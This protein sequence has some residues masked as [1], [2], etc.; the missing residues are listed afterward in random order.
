M[1][2]N[3]LETYKVVENGQALV[4]IPADRNIPDAVGLIQSSLPTCCEY[5]VRYA[6]ARLRGKNIRDAH[7]EALRGANVIARK[8]DLDQAGALEL[9]PGFE[10]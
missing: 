3:A 7:T 8:G 4:I 1:R 10:G 5:L 9:P 2:V 6:D